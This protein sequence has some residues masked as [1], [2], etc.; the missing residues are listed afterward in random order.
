[1]KKIIL[2]YGLIA[3]AIVAAMMFITMPMY[4]SGALKID[5]G[6]IVGYTTM[7]IALS[8]VFFGIKSFRDN[9]QNGA[10]TFGRGLKVG[11]LITVIASVMYALAWEVSYASIG[12]EFTQKMQEHYIK[13]MEAKG[14]TPA[15]ISKA[16]EE[17]Y[18]FIDL[19]RNPFVRFGITLFEIFPVGL[20]I[21]LLS[22][23]LLRK[24]EFLPAS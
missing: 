1:M 23:G 24:K 3:G 12:E 13:K 11:V 20:V 15:E 7:V 6:E 5:N 17:M 4:K 2:T 8:M 10:I 18:G 21:S 16:K 22:A 9:H 19:Y 14:A